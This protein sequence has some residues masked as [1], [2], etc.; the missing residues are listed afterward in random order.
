M[1]ESPYSLRYLCCVNNK[2]K[3]VEKPCRY[4]KTVSLC[5]FQLFRSLGCTL[6]DAH[7]CCN[8][9]YQYEYFGYFGVLVSYCGISILIAWKPS[10]KTQKKLW[11][12][13]SGCW[14]TLLPWLKKKIEK[15]RHLIYTRRICSIRNFRKVYF[16][17][18]IRGIFHCALS[19]VDVLWHNSQLYFG[20]RITL[21]WY[22]SQLF[23]IIRNCTL[24]FVSSGI[25]VL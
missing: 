25:T 5:I 14:I 1:I 4:G 23:F 24:L 13:R 22:D 7:Q 19:F 21:L 3:L 9:V 2:L 6:R 8:K 10:R 12:P 16:G 18:I 17:I 20:I 15:N 11:T